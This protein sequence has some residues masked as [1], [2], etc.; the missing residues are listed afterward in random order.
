VREPRPHSIFYPGPDQK[1]VP[2]SFP[3]GGEEPNPI[4]DD[5]DGKAGYP[6]TATFPETTPMRGARATLKDAKGQLVACWLS[7][8]EQPANPK[9]ARLQGNTVCLIPHDP[10]APQQTY[11]VELRGELDG[12]PWE[13]SWQFTTASDDL[14]SA[15]AAEQVVARLNRFRR[16][17]GLP[18]VTVDAELSRGCLAHAEYLVRN[19][20]ALRKQKRTVNDEDP[21]LPGFT[22]HGLSASKRADVY[23]NAPVPVSQVDDLL[24]TF[25]RRVYLLDPNLRRIGFGCAH[26]VG[27]GWRCVLDLIGGR[28]DTRVVM[29]PG[30]GQEG[31]PCAGA[32]HLPDAADET[33]GFPITVTFPAGAVVRGAQAV[34]SEVGGGEVEVTLS[35][36]E[37]P[38]SPK[39]PRS[40]VAVYPRRP[41]AAGRVYSV[42]VSA[43]VGGSEW[44]QS[45]QFTTAAENKKR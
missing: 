43:I 45:W 19:T 34:L 31:V 16:D 14:T 35:T 1:E 26:D 17:T 11:H 36:P 18:A 27:R 40:T 37:A 21:A 30:P 7:T 20:E 13:K 22:P 2:L 25:L 29:Y 33:V 41:L 9:F 28:G 42:T 6:I 15:Q 32:D 24:A 23:S 12:R 3:P 5:K 4:P 10:L 8:P 39:S 44:R 38:L